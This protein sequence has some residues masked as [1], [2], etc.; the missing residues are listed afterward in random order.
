M[1]RTAGFTLIELLVVLAIIGIISA[2]AVPALL[3]QRDR[4]RAAAV[5]DNHAAC[6]GDL[7]AILGE[8]S[9]PPSDRA[10]GYSSTVW[11]GSQASNIAKA[12]KAIQ[13][14]LAKTNFASAHNPYDSTAAYMAG[15]TPTPGGR[16]RG[17]V[18]LDSATAGTTVDPVITVTSVYSGA[19]GQTVQESKTVAV[20]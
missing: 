13:T 20:N 15:V 2:I 8:L 6:I 10:A 1:T 11:D 7:T 18:T 16:K 19:S 4:A 14:M 17:R 5:K 9:E 12:D 3:G